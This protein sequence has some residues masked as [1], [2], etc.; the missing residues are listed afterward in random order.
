MIRTLLLFVALVVGTACSNQAAQTKQYHRLAVTL[1]S[2]DQPTQ[3]GVLVVKRPEA[4]SILGGRPMVATQDNGALIQ[5][6]HNFWLESP[7]ILI[8]DVLMNWASSHWQSVSKQTP[9]GSPFQ[10]LDTRI[11]A[12]EKNGDQIHLTLAF[13]LTDEKQQTLLEKTIDHQASIQGPGHAA[14]AKAMGLAVAAAL[15]E[16]GAAL[17]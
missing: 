6:S 16:L 12:F 1:P 10:Q 17:P 2:A 5:L 15:S 9:Y 7:K 3:A 14:A 4:L 13:K 8:H 11:L